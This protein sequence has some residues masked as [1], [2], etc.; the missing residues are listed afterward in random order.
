MKPSGKLY[1]IPNT[2]MGGPEST[3]PGVYEAV[4][5]EIDKMSKEMF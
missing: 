5:E 3:Y 4:T 2:T 1:Y